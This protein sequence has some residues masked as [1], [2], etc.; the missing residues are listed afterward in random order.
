MPDIC[1]VMMRAAMTTIY[2]GPP[3]EQRDWFGGQRFGW[4]N[5]HARLKPG[6]TIEEARAEMGLLLSQLA[7]TNQGVGRKETVRVESISEVRADND[8]W[9]L[10]AMVLG[11]SGLVLLIACVNIANM[12]LARAASRQKEIVVRLCLG[13]SRGVVRQIQTKVCIGC[14]GC[15]RVLPPVESGLLLLRPH[16]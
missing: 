6:K 11:A 1:C 13:A 10:M 8:V 5:L 15:T 7:R 12:Q 14:M 16:T 4:L 3:P 2:F 9:G